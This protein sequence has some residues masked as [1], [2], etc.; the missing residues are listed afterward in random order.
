MVTTLGYGGFLMGPVL[1][2]VLAESFGLRLALGTIVIAGV[3]V[4]AISSRLGT[5]LERP[6]RP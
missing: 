1:V 6:A 5:R 2:G 4:V 3:L